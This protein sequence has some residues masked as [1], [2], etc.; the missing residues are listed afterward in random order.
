MNP[1]ELPAAPYRYFER[2]PAPELRA[3]ISTWWAFAVPRNHD[4]AQLH[5]V[6]PDGCTSLMIVP[7]A[8]SILSGP[9]VN[10]CMVP[11]VPGGL[12]WGAR[13]QPYGAALALGV[14]PQR[15]RDRAQ[16]AAAL[17]G[18][19]A[20]AF[21]ALGRDAVDLDALAP[22]LD[23]FFA[24]RAGE[25]PRPD[26]L[27]RT[28]AAVLRASGGEVGIARLAAE[29]DAS[30]RTLLRRF[31]RATGLAPKEFARIT[32]L[33]R[34]AHSLLPQGMP[35]WARLAVELGYADQPHLV[36]EFR[37]LTGLSPQGFLARVRATAHDFPP[38]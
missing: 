37:E 9:W 16:P 11:V 23:A 19:M 20:G 8:G 6:P 13:F 26:P 1:P 35:E 36:R 14:D 3:W 12:Y 7:G 32:R 25:W 28:A 33:L 18:D 30:P 34:T 22:R 21:G 17:L 31:R 4:P 5:H 29:L 27:V 15:L 2:L 24:A 10:A 38:R